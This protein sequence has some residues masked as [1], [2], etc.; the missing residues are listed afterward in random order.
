M[1]HY[2]AHLVIR[3]DYIRKDGT[4]AIYIVSYIN[5]KKLMIPTGLHVCPEHFKAEAQVVA[6][7]GNKKT[8][9]GYNL[10]LKNQLGKVHNIFTAYRLMDE[11]L[12]AQRFKAE[13]DDPRARLDLV[14]FIRSECVKLKGVMV[15]ATITSYQGTIKKLL[16]YAPT[17][18]FNTIDYA[19]VNELDRR[20]KRQRLKQNTIYKHHKNIK[21]FLG[22][23]ERQGVRFTNP[24]KEFKAG[25]GEGNRNSLTQQELQ[26]VWQAYCNLDKKDVL[27]PKA[28][29]FLLSCLMGGFRLSDLN[30]VTRQNIIGEYLVFCPRKT[31]RY[32][33]QVRIPLTDTTQDLLRV[34]WDSDV[35][36]Q[37][38]QAINKG[39]KQLRVLAGIDKPLTFHIS[40]HTYATLFL[41]LGGAPEVLMQIMGI[42]KWDTVK[43]YI[44]IANSRVKQQAWQ[45]DGHMKELLHS[46]QADLV[47]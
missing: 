41:E 37:C 15:P 36:R 21:K 14:G 19:M 38:H 44:H 12:T 20:W 33:K 17:I 22:E 29:A 47:S 9:D 31:M 18:P 35:Q 16:E 46:M 27:R 7:P 2:S 42:S 23:A 32:N 24:Y 25:R 5:R 26:E 11:Q 34:V 8:T 1:H 3:G 6:I 30:K 40:R 28:A 39:L 10:Y 43:V 4:C 13:F 45:Y